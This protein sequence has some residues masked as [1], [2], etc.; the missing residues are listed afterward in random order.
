MVNRA[1]KLI[2]LLINIIFISSCASLYTYKSHYTDI[3]RYIQSGD[4]ESALEALNNVKMSQYT[5]KDRLLFYLEKGMLCRYAGLYEDSNNYLTKAENAI[6]ELEIKSI[7]KGILSGV[8][9]DNALDYSGEDYEDIYINIFKAL[10]YLEL[11]KNDEA[12][13]EIRRA[14]DKLRYLKDK[15]Q[16]SINE[17]NSKNNVEIPTAEFFLHNN[18][19][20]RYLGI[21]AYRLDR[22]YDDSRIEKDFFEDAYFTQPTV[23]DFPKPITP[24]TSKPD[25]AIINIFSYS[26]FAPEKVADTIV[27]ST[28]SNRIFLG[29]DSGNDNYTN[30]YLGFSSIANTGVSEGVNLKMQFPR[31]VSIYDPVAYVE[32]LVNN[33]RIGE[34][35]L[36]ES[37][38]NVAI[39]T[40]KVKQ[41]LI[42]GKTVV[43]AIGKAILSEASESAIKDNFGDGWGALASLAGSI[44]M[45]V[46]ENSDL[47]TARY[48][49]K[50]I[51]GIEIQLLPGTY[52]FSIVYYD[53]YM[54]MI[55]KDYYNNYIVD[56]DGLNL[57][58]SQLFRKN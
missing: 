29:A 7:S 56:Q 1:I 57:I 22:E 13:V 19:F 52:D 49:P 33:N 18:A 24:I 32:V 17:Y 58:E 9:N 5:K 16:N 42:V 51:R 34:L 8:L 20:A 53:E 27:V 31:L 21:I 55:F 54:N 14:N 50:N 28:G 12:L 4:P 11:D 37:V 36:I 30:S 41:P 45:Q 48:F 6:E 44:Y 39:E 15:Y 35:E 3:D 26:G 25:S 23:Y 38:D 47:R 10:N 40:F 46:T 43:R 2:V